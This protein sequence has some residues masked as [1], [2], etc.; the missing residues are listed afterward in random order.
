VPASAPQAVF[1]IRE[2]PSWALTRLSRCSE[3]WN[4]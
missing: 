2:S 3:V 1:V 4:F